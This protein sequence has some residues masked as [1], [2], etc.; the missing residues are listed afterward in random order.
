MELLI[1]DER[2]AE[3]KWKDV[4]FKYRTSVSSEDKFA[5]DTSGKILKGDKIE[6][7]FW[8]FYTTMI[9]V[10]VVDWNGVTS[11]GKPV[12]YSYETFLKKFPG[13]L[14]EDLIML[15]GA[16]IAY[17]TGFLQE[18]KIKEK[19]KIKNGLGGPSNG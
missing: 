15:L 9:R 5:V 8:D 12:P 13:D 10:F 14:Q 17:A 16:K 11:S 4:T 19:T 6:F 3:F 1:L 2:P 7:S 18:E